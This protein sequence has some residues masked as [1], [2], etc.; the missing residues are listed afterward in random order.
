MKKILIT[1]VL[2]LILSGCSSMNQNNL[3]LSSSNVTIEPPI[4]NEKNGGISLNESYSPSEEQDK[5]F[6]EFELEAI[7]LYFPE[8]QYVL[9]V[10]NFTNHSND[11]YIRYLFS[12]LSSSNLKS[13]TNIP[14]SD[15]NGFRCSTDLC[16]DVLFNI[17]FTA[18]SD[19]CDSYLQED[20]G[21]YIIPKKDIHSVLDKYFTD[22]DLDIHN[23]SYN[24]EYINDGEYIVSPG[25]DS[26]IQTF[27]GGYEIT[28][29]DDNSDGTVSIS[30]TVNKVEEINDMFVISDQI[31]SIHTFTIKP[32]NNKCIILSY[33]I[34]HCN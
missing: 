13:I 19:Q 27:H 20:T 6:P 1:L 17:F 24:F 34:E 21:K 25:F 16:S 30:L 22:Y 2:V 3:D 32:E 31:E 4:S 11:E 15:Y 18:T 5:T 28:S 29:I 33:F 12:L 26:I 23:L 8:N 14:Y 10:E 9:N 7:D